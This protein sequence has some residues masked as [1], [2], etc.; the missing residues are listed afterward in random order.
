MEYI[1]DLIIELLK[2]YPWFAAFLSVV[3]IL[4][5]VFK[6]LCALISAIVEA[7]PTQVDNEFWEDLQESKLWKFL[8]WLLDYLASIKLPKGK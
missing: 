7:T 8:I 3:G 4:R 2:Q 6:P 5:L 1:I